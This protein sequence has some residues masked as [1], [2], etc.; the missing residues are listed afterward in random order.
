VPCPI[1]RSSRSSLIQKE[2]ASTDSTRSAAYTERLVNLV[3]CADCTF[4]YVERDFPES[5]V[6]AFY[7][8]RAGGGYHLDYEN[9]FWWHEATK[10]SNRHILSL[11]GPAN[12]QRLLELGCGNGT[13]LADAR[14]AGWQV[15][16]LEINPAFRDFCRDELKIEDVHCGLVNDPPF[17]PASFDVVAMLDVLEHMYD[18]IVSLTQCVRLL[19]PNGRMVVKSPNG[20]MQLRKERFKKKLGRGTGFV[21]NI[22]HIN[23][24]TPQTLALAFRKCGLEPQKICPAKSFQEG[25]TGAGFTPKRVARHIAVLAANAAMQVS[26]VGLNLVGIARK[27]AAV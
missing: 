22:G 4:V 27:T 26:G 11:L 21:A 10:H 2:P 8:E 23:Q 16:G 18:P 5:Y 9:F 15:S 6:N 1:C 13:F 17:A 20:A 14:D 24:F 25:I 3:A 7:E 19:K 12:G